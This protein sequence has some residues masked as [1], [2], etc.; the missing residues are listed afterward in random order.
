MLVLRIQD[1]RLMAARRSKM[2]I[3]MVQ[4]KMNLS[5]F[6]MELLPIATRSENFWHQRW[7]CKN[8]KYF[9][10]FLKIEFLLAKF[11]DFV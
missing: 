2:P 7:G 5:L 9:F 3:P 10:E 1:G 8:A 6:I 4:Q 11:R